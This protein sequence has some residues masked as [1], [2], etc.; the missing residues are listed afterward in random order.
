MLKNLIKVTLL[1]VWQLLLHVLHVSVQ[2][3]L[4]IKNGVVIFRMHD[5]WMLNLLLHFIDFVDRIYIILSYVLKTYSISFACWMKANSH[6]KAEAK[7][8]H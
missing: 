8:H 4:T 6:K 7:A 5:T 2:I 3:R 1:L